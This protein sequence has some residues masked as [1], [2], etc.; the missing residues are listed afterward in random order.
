MESSLLGQLQ[1]YL[2]SIRLQFIFKYS[3]EGTYGAILFN[4]FEEKIKVNKNY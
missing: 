1:Y 2:V 3:M 4:N